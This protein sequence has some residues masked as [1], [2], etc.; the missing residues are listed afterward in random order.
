MNNKK[1]EIDT[2]SDQI[3][4][5][6]EQIDSLLDLMRKASDS[7]ETKSIIVASEI[8]FTIYDELR[9]DIYKLTNTINSRGE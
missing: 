3:E 7:V 8:L 6:F 4:T 2:I 5:L 9:C 1:I